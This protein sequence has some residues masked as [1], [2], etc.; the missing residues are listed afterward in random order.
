MTGEMHRTKNTMAIHHYAST[1]HSLSER[2]KNVCLRG[3]YGLLGARGFAFLE[4]NFNKSMER[5]IRK[6]LP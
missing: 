2:I 5:K 6:E 3:V 1:W 4:K